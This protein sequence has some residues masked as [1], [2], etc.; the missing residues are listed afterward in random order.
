MTEIIGY[1]AA[2]LTTV[3]F[4]PQVVKTIKTKDTSGISLLM[5]SIFVSGVFLW[6]IYGILLKNIVITSANLL[7]FILAGLVLLIKLRSEIKGRKSGG[8]GRNRTD[9]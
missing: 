8:R 3:S 1:I 4:L 2:F 6:L 7:T 5:Y 9:V